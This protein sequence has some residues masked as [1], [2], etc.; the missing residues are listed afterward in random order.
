[1]TIATC[2]SA[3]TLVRIVNNYGGDD[4]LSA[5]GIGQRILTFA[6]MPSNVL[7]QA[8]QPILGFNYGAKKFRQALKSINLT[9][10]I[11][12]GVGLAILAILVA[13]PGRLSESS[14]PTPDSSKSLP[15]LPG[16]CSWGYR[17]TA[18]STSDRWCFLPSVKSGRL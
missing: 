5:F 7:S 14:L 3:L 9:V 15:M 11:S 12:F 17:Y 1:M 10:F 8:M 4:A 13:I 2:I 16:L 6:S 18:S